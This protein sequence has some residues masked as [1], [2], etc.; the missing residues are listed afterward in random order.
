MG[1]RR[2]HPNNTGHFTKLIRSTMDEP[3]W[4]ALKPSAQ[5]LYPWLKLEWRGLKYNNNGKIRLSLKQAAERMGVVVDTAAS[6]FHDLQRMGFI[7][8]T[9]P[10]QLGMGGHARPTA[11]ELTELELPN[12]DAISGRKL[13]RD[14]RKGQNFPVHKPSSNNPSG[15]NG[16]TKPLPKI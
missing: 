6:A 8:V 2:N 4:K 3:A 13:Y 9:Q 14:W 15:R 1:N 12:S 16:K 7:V 10:A 5:A 11:Y